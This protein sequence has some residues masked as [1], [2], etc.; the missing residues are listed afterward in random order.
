MSALFVR[1]KCFLLSAFKDKESLANE[2][3]VVLR[4]SNGR[5]VLS[6]TDRESLIAGNVTMQLEMI[7]EVLK[8]TAQIEDRILETRFLLTTT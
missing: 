3:V 7:S 2:K 5:I 1:Y 6:W 4:Q 8:F